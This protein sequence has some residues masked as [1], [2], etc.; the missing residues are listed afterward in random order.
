VHDN[1]SKTGDGASRVLSRGA[2]PAKVREMP[3]SAT[4]RSR[5]GTMI[6]SLSRR[7]LGIAGIACLLAAPSVH[8]QLAIGDLVAADD[9]ANTLWRVTSAGTISSYATGLSAGPFSVAIDASGNV[10]V[11]NGNGLIQRVAPGGTITNLGNAGTSLIGGIAVDGSGNY[12]IASFNGTI[13][14][15]TPAGTL[16]TVATPGGTTWGIGID[17]AGDYIVSRQPNTVVRVTPTGTV[18]TIATV[19][20]QSFLQG[21]TVGSDG[22][23]YVG[24]ESPSAVYRV[25]PTGVVTTLHTGAPYSDPGE[26]LAFSGGTLYVPDDSAAGGPAIF[27]QNPAGGAPTVFVSGAPF[28]GMSGIAIN[29]TAAPPPPVV[30]AEV[31]VF[32]PLGLALLAV[33]LGAAGAV[34]ARRREPR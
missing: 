9:G 5:E 6:K 20:S 12:I 16:S 8:A 29:G 22:N 14:R 32:G 21:L 1:L 27:R 2:D 34:G 7:A 24:A 19:P 18:S 3:F 11:G 31:P 17:G 13:Y 33:L 23:Y 28:Q 26:G 25:T 4:I 15:M 10:I 30:A